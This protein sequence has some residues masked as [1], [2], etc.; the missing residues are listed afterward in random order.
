[1]GGTPASEIKD[2]III[3][4]KLEKVKA[5]NNGKLFYLSATAIFSYIGRLPNTDFIKIK[6]NTDKE[7]YFLVDCYNSTSVP[8]LFAAGDITCKLK[9]AITACGDGANA[10]YFANK[11]IQNNS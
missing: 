9:Q 1:L 3:N 11:Y 6:I 5:S 8:G 10:Y 2:F 4:K 7:G